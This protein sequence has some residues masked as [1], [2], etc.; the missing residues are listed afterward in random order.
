MTFQRKRQ[1]HNY[2]IAGCFD[3]ETSNNEGFEA[4]PVCYQF[5]QLREALQPVRDLTNETVAGA[6]EVFIDRDYREAYARFDALIERYAKL[7]VVPVVMVHNLAFE[8]WALSPYIAKHDAEG[9]SKSC[10]KPLTIV[11]KD[12]KG[13]P[14]LVFWDTLSFAG[15]SLATLGDEC[16]Y[17]KLTGSWDYLKH[18]TTATPLSEAE[19]AYAREDVIVPF[20]WLAYHLTLTG[21]DESKLACRILTKTSAVRY[22]VGSTIGGKH[23][24]RNCTI[25]RDWARRNAAEEPGTDDELY[26]IHAGTRGGFTYCAR[27][28]ASHVFKADSAHKIYKFDACSM[29]PFHALAH[30]VPSNYREI[31]PAK[32]LQLFEHVQA[33]EPAQILANYHAPFHGANFYGAFH[34]ENLRIKPGSV[35]ERDGISSFASSRFNLRPVKSQLEDN[36]GGF[37]FKEHIAALGYCDVATSDAVFAFGKFFGASGAVLWLNELSAWELSRQFV[38]DSVQPVNTCY[39]TGQIMEPTKRSVMAFNLMYKNKSLFKKAKGQYEHGETVDPLEFVPDYL[40]EAMQRHEPAVKQDV[41]LFYLSTKA[42][43][44]ALYG[45][46]ATNEAKPE[47]LLDPESGY[48]VSESRGVEALPQRP[49]TWFQYGSHIVGWSRIHQI[50]FIE[51]VS[52]ATDAVFINGDTDSHK[53][54]TTASL[55]EIEAALRPLHEACAATIETN[56]RILPEWY[57]WYPMDGLGLYECEGSPEQFVAAWNKCY[58]ELEGGRIDLT[59]AGVPCDKRFAMPDGSIIDHSYNRIANLLY[60]RGESFEEI[61]G[62]MIGY[63]VSISSNITGMNLRTLPKWNTF[64]ADGQPCAVHL[65][66]MLKTIGDTTKATNWVNSLYALDNNPDVNVEPLMIDWPLELDEPVIMEI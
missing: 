22:K 54:Y 13:E 43:L 56:R 38:W 27:S 62:K 19:E 26:T 4:Q 47:I 66:P 46:E 52:A 7:P 42:D 14:A 37:E 10:V 33:I 64:G 31:S 6:L 34:F 24:A 65:S 53:I 61:T 9:C 28:Y 18:R 55:D 44:N 48:E 40:M 30:Y 25:D 15:K 49:K 41:E 23:I 60:E 2:K 1:Q 5:S 35:Y 8:L 59:M 57:E 11:I 50:L 12:A 39:A 17:P 21:L 3:I 58:A 51:L 32:A 29:H 45:I 16:G 20:A 36:E 63:N